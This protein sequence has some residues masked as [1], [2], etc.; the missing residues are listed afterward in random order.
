MLGVFGSFYDGYQKREDEWR[1]QRVENARAFSEFKRSNPYASFSEYQTFIDGLTGGDNYLR[2]G[3]PSQ[4]VLQAITSEGQKLRQQEMLSRQLDIINK[5]A[6]TEGT[7]SALAER[8]S[9]QYDDDAK[10]EE[11]LIGQLGGDQTGAREMIKRMYPGGFK[12]IRER[13]KASLFNQ[14]LPKAIDFLEKNPN[15]EL[16]REL[17]PGVDPKLFSD[18]AGIAKSQAERKYRETQDKLYGQTL[19]AGIKAMKEGVDFTPPNNMAP[20]YLDRYKRDMGSART[21]WDKDR[22]DIKTKE[23]QQKL[24]QLRISLNQDRD[25]IKQMLL[26]PRTDTET[27]RSEI[28]KRLPAFGLD[29]VSRD[30]MDALIRELVADAQG[31]QRN[32]YERNQ[33]ELQTQAE[34][35]VDDAQKRNELSV[36][37]NFASEALKPRMGDDLSAGVASEAIKIISSIYDIDGQATAA[38]N[39]AVSDPQVQRAIKGAKGNV[40]IAQQALMS[41]PDVAATLQT[42]QRSMTR[43]QLRQEFM[44]ANGLPQRQPAPQF[45]NSYARETTTKRD[46]WMS[47]LQKGM[48]SSAPPEAKLAALEAIKREM[49]V[50]ARMAEVGMNRALQTAS[51]WAIPG[52]GTL[53]EEEAAR[54]KADRMQAI[55]DVLTAVDTAIGQLRSLQQNAPGAPRPAPT[56]Q[57]PAEKPWNFADTPAGRTWDWLTT[58]AQAQQLPPAVQSLLGPKGPPAGPALNGEDAY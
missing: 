29:D 52:Q 46:S 15:A 7:L 3:L 43:T 25:G 40:Q 19:D 42:R 23:R 5:Q 41:H 24:G 45:L 35:A 33:R 31:S 47:K 27:V 49:G 36:K 11:A 21:K 57:A 53:S 56:A 17:F 39:K 8:N 6:Q 34:S 26:D 14:F 2:G 10:L 12:A 16:P 30:E 20:E 38:L 50:E 13:A 58:P 44:A 51:V 18:F 9:L 22:A 55:Q 54:A 48:S 37:S 1:R 32:I 4:Q 28:T